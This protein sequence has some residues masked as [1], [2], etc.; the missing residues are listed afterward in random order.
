MRRCPENIAFNRLSSRVRLAQVPS[1]L[2]IIISLKINRKHGREICIEIDSNKVG[3]P[4]VA[5][6][7]VVNP[8]TI[9]NRFLLRMFLTISCLCS[10]MLSFRIFSFPQTRWN[11][12]MSIIRLLWQLVVN[13]FDQN[14]FELSPVFTLYFRECQT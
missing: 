13:Y 4:S 12:S 1:Q 7:C 6:V 14:V 11:D 9:L 10:L 3:R 2:H 8:F 5:N